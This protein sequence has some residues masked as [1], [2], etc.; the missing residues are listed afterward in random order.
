[1]FATRHIHSLWQELWDLETRNKLH[2][3]KPR[4]NMW[5]IIPTRVTDVK[6]TRLRIGHTRVTH[7]HLLFG[8]SAPE[9]RPCRTNFTVAHILTEYPTFNSHRVTYFNSSSPNMKELLGE[10]PHPHLF[11]FL[12]AIGFYHSI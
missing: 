10:L 12:K 5:S 3:I 9:C 1:M 7:R 4:I 6:L 8:E 2:L 11:D